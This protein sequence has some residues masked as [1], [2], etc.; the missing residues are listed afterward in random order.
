MHTL[1]RYRLAEQW[2]HSEK[3]LEEARRLLEVV[4]KAEP[5]LNKCE[6]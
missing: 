1:A 3:K 5:E 4:M 6:V 2:I